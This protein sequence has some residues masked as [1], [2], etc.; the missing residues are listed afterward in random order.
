VDEVLAVG[1]AEFQKKAIGKMQE[2]S[3]GGGRTVLF[4]SHNMASIQALCTKGIV[5][6]NGSISFV[7][8][9]EKSVTHYLSLNKQI[10]FSKHISERVDR[11]NAKEF[12]FV[13]I[14]IH[15]ENGKDLNALSSGDYYKFKIGY[16]LKDNKYL[17]GFRMLLVDEKGVIR[18]LCNSVL[19][20]A[21]PQLFIATQSGEFAF[22]IE[23]F[24]LPKGNYSVQLTCYSQ[25]GIEDDIENALHF[26]V[27]GGDFYG[28]GREAVVKEGVLVEY[29]CSL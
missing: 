2:V 29:R 13:S 4:V 20:G 11:V 21:T 7:G 3:Q 27:E 18:I 8:N 28:F 12:K 16:V 24:P 15:D 5:M 9:I 17:V 1:D 6:Y 14:N 23:K 10:Y 26:S 22:I 25:D 19:V